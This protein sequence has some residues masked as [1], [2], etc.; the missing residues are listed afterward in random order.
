MEMGQFMSTSYILVLVTTKDKI[1]AEKIAQ[2]LLEEKIIACANIIEH[3]NSHF[4][5]SGEI[6][7][8]EECLM[9]MKS[10]IDL[11]SELTRR[12]KALHSYKIPEILAIPIVVGSDD[13]LTWIDETL[14]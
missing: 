5:W 11:F 3:V 8:S 4:R 6:D 1:E 7:E 2:K 13:Y 14:K 12:V 9:V 10:R